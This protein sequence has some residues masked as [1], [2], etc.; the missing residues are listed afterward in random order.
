MSDRA[1][2]RFMPSVVEQ[3]C[4]KHFGSHSIVLKN[5]FSARSERPS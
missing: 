2:K 5:S 1:E 4:E 3:D